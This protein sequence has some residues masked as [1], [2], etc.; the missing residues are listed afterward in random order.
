MDEEEEERH[1]INAASKREDVCG[2][3]H[4]SSIEI[5]HS[6]GK[7]SHD[8]FVDSSPKECHYRIVQ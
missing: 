7:F 2:Q 5:I 3:W 4:N 8:Y 1:E 6:L